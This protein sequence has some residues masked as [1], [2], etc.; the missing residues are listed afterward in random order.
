MATTSDVP[1]GQ[2]ERRVGDVALPSFGGMSSR[3]KFDI[4]RFRAEQIAPLAQF[5]PYIMGANALAV[6]VVVWSTLTSVGGPWLYLWAMCQ[7]GLT[8]T[9]LYSWFH[10]RNF[11]GANRRTVT[12][13]EAGSL[14]FALLWAFPT[15]ELM[16]AIPV[17]AQHV[18]LG[19][20]FITAVTGAFALTR[21][22]LASIT[23]A[24]VVSGAL[25]VSQIRRGEDVD[26]L[27][28]FIAVAVAFLMSLMSVALNRTLMRRAADNYHMNRQSEFLALLLKD[29][30]VCSSDLLWETD[31]EGKLI[32]FSDRL[33]SLL[34]TSKLLLGRTLQE[35]AGASPTD[36]GWSDFTLL[37]GNRQT[38]DGLC[39][40]VRRTTRTDWWMLTAQPL[41]GHAQE[42]LG[43]RGV[44]RDI[45][46]ERRA[47]LDLITAKE[48]AER[49][50]TAK[51][52]FLAVTSHELK[53][54][55]N[56]IVGFSEML[57]AQREGPLGSPVYAEYAATILQS[58]TH[59]RNIIA[60]ILDVTRIERGTLHLV[61]QEM[62]AAEILE[63]AYK[64][65]R[66][67]AKAADI[68]LSAD[69]ENTAE[70][71]GDITRIRQVLINLVTNAIKF[72][73][74]GNAIAL[75]IEHQPDGG[76]AFVIEDNGIGIAPD[77]LERVFEPFEQGDASSSRRHGG[78]GLGLA[79][80]RKIARMHD[81]DVVLDSVLD[82]GTTA[83]FI[84]P[85]VRVKWPQPVVT[86]EA[87]PEE[88]SGAR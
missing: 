33:P 52:Q 70:I 7:A 32:Y 73:R 11:A 10:N 4:S 13:I 55:L 24:A 42:F 61:E 40:E 26:L 23:F 30:E 21:L 15:L 19:V 58:S 48:A 44:I 86:D 28:G 45:S 74:P 41:W 43:Y 16:P 59:L 79:I 63:V 50:S 62:D 83:R 31:D 54:P 80:A 6:M 85:P 18:V 25:F 36:Q 87:A 14:A 84:L 64:M 5:R 9:V 29:F 72:S 67:Q 1:R 34:G 27:L 49:A 65:C 38:I 17:E 71:E 53:T 46:L 39:L 66:E 20:C 56:A 76:L 8:A 57:I 60:D 47:Q 37:C 22:P 88:S 2:M 81:G 69:L 82:D 3:P 35:A 78:I 75:W 12:A 68:P 51:S 77:D